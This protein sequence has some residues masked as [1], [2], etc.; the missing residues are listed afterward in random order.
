MQKTKP[1]LYLDWCSHKAAKYACENWHYSKCVPK[2]KLA[3]IGVWENDCF[4][5]CVLFG[6]GANSNVI[7]Q[8]GLENNQGCELV[9]V[10][11]K[12][13]IS[14]VS[15]I[16]AKAI[17]ILKKHFSKLQI[18][19][20]YSDIGQNHHGGIYQAAN[21]MYLGVTR[22]NCIKAI[23]IKNIEYHQR[24]VSRKYGTVN[25]DYIRNNI[26]KNAKRVY[27]DGKHKY[28]YPLSD[29]IFNKYK[30]ET[31]PYPKRTK[32]EAS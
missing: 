22:K 13:H 31:K 12:A 21:W 1:K 6:Y 30:N 15:K 32:K 4:I 24:T 29:D 26:D 9:R 20:S 5:G 16:L 7:I 10:A 18:L 8:F 3:K 11:L 14:P 2:G 27:D 25:I 28:I 23:R 17:K 19:I